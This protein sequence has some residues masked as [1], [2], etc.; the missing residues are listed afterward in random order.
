M[1]GDASILQKAV[2]SDNHRV[3]ILHSHV[4]IWQNFEESERER[5]SRMLH[6]HF[7]AWSGI[8][9]KQ[10]YLAHLGICANLE[11]CTLNLKWAIAHY[12]LCISS[13]QLCILFNHPFKLCCLRKLLKLGDWNEVQY[14]LGDFGT[15][16]PTN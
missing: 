4:L 1:G 10:Q 16:L 12:L 8:V 13:T 11:E 15:C 7:Q 9:S 14:V 2:K 3:H 5:D 6:F